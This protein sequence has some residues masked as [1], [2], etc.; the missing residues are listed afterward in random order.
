MRSS[1]HLTQ[2]NTTVTLSILKLFHWKYSAFSSHI[3]T[4]FQPVEIA[5]KLRKCFDTSHI[6]ETSNLI[7]PS[8]RI[9]HRQLFSDCKQ[10]TIA[11]TTAL[12]NERCTSAGG[13]RGSRRVNRAIFPSKGTAD[14]SRKGEAGAQQFLPLTTSLRGAR[15][16]HYPCVTSWKRGGF[17][18]RFPRDRDFTVNANSTGD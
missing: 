8:R 6:D 9:N 18:S 17:R 3:P 12:K 4:T 16:H 7:I 5:H 11:S 1:N 15:L 14:P 2:L 13:S 10:L